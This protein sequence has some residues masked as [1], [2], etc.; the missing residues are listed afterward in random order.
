MLLATSLT[1][2]RIYTFDQSPSYRRRFGSILAAAMLALSVI[3]CMLDERKGHQTAF[4][5]M[6]AAV[7]WRTEKV[8]G[9]RIKDEDVRRRVRGL[10]RKGT[11]RSRPCLIF[12]LAGLE[13]F[14]CLEHD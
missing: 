1:L 10:A 6:V 9:A 13:I 8:I 11:C 14:G 5:V 2:H 4:V 3:H 12:L 7:A